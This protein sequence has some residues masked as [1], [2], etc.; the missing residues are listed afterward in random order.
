MASGTNTIADGP[1]WVL[2]GLRT[3]Q[4]RWKVCVPL[5]D[6][7]VTVHRPLPRGSGG[8]IVGTVRLDDIALD[9]EGSVSSH[10]I[11]WQT[12]NDIPFQISLSLR[13]CS[14]YW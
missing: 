8:G 1:S 14:S 11:E 9:E 6:S 3:D 2:L 12:R 4:N 7:T 13:Y 10:M 5:I